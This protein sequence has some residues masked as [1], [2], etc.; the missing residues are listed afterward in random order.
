MYN[1][2]AHAII[3]IAGII[4][5]AVLFY[6][7]IK[8]VDYKKIQKTFL[9]P[10]QDY[11]KKSSAELYQE[12]AVRQRKYMNIILTLILTVLVI[13]AILIFFQIVISI[14]NQYY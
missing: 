2:E 5:T 3:L 1:T 14:E 12:T 10:E 9:E 7:L 11:Y 13:I 6:L 8:L 4:I